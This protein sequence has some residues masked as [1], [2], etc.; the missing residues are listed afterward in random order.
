M[1]EEGPA[2]GRNPSSEKQSRKVEANE[3]QLAG[4]QQRCPGKS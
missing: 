1:I 4:C 2:Q 3:K